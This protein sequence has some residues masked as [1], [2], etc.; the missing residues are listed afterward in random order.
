MIMKRIIVLMV[1]LLAVFGM[2]WY[3]REEKDVGLLKG[4]ICMVFSQKMDD[5]EVLFGIRCDSANF[6]TGAKYI[7]IP[8]VVEN[9]YIVAKTTGTFKDIFF[10][11][12]KPV[13]PKVN[14]VDYKCE[15]TYFVV[16]DD[17]D[18]KYIIFNE[19]S[20]MGPYNVVDTILCWGQTFIYVRDKDSFLKMFTL[21]GEEFIPDQPEIREIVFVTDTLDTRIE[22]YQFVKTDAW[23]RV[24]M[25]ELLDSV[26]VALVDSLKFSDDFHVLTDGIYELFKKS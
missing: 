24:G 18:Q 6:Y 17:L 8:T 16:E 11:S 5:N 7:E 23:I 15:S 9:G 3:S 10:P 19:D 12:L 13:L 26:D 14:K 25:G 21:T 4:T 2:D 22:K 1:I 20:V